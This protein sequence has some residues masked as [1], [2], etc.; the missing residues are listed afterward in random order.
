M[1]KLTH[2]STAHTPTKSLGDCR[3]SAFGVV[4][5]TCV[6]VFSTIGNNDV[7]MSL[8]TTKVLQSNECQKVDTHIGG[9]RT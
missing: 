5:L 4:D 9:I 3:R 2:A 8:S 1:R 6:R 7:P